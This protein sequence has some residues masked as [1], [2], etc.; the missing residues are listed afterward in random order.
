MN[1]SVITPI[2]TPTLSPS[3]VAPNGPASHWGTGRTDSG[4][5][6]SVP[7]AEIDTTS[8]VPS[9]PDRPSSPK[10]VRGEPERVF[11]PESR[12]SNAPASVA[13]SGP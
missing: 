4:S 2:S 10:R 11:R 3:P 13:P 6:E 8:P 1:I 5:S 12:S 9:S 7:A